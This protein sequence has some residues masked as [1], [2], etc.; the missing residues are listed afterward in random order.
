M[1]QSNKEFQFIEPN[2]NSIKE[3]S[4]IGGVELTKSKIERLKTTL[5]NVERVELLRFQLDADIYDNFL[6]FCTNLKTLRINPRFND[7]KWLLYEYRKLENI[8]ITFSNEFA[9]LKTFLERNPSIRYMEMYT[10]FIFINA[11][12]LMTVN[13]TINEL[14]IHCY[15][16]NHLESVCNLLGALYKRQFYEYLKII[17]ISFN[18]KC[19]DLLAKLSPITAMNIHTS[20]ENII[21]AEM[22]YLKEIEFGTSKDFG[23]KSFVSNAVNLERA[24]LSMPKFDHM[25]C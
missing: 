13:A 11:E 15:N 24:I 18:Q 9:E 17:V 14:A 3:I 4:F 12:T 19:A 23:I 25:L 1:I 16:V 5:A 20:D 8:H 7:S 22:K 10:S 6:K 21:W 2:C